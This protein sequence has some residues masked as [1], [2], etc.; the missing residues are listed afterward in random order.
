[1]EFPRR[2]GQAL[3]KKLPPGVGGKPGMLAH[4]GRACR[5]WPLPS[6]HLV[7]GTHMAIGKDIINEEQWKA[8]EKLVG[9]SWDQLLQWVLVVY[10]GMWV[11][12]GWVDSAPTL[13]P[14]FT[15]GL[16]VAA[17]L[18]LP[19]GDWATS[20]THWQTTLA[21][22]WLPGTVIV[23][24]AILAASL[25]H[26]PGGSGRMALTVAATLF[27][28][29]LTGDPATTLLWVTALSAGPAIISLLLYAAGRV[30]G[31]E[32][33][34]LE[35]DPRLTLARFVTGPLSPILVTVLAPLILFGQLVERYGYVSHY[36]AP[37][38]AIPLPQ[39]DASN[40]ERPDVV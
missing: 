7:E 15:W 29:E 21:P 36:R 25:A 1:M 27:A 22:E 14:P 39:R 32:P 26:A 3:T 12:W 13:Q 8:V 35:Y 2:I 37:T 9:L 20:L 30:R 4:L 33:G 6:H 38:G 10:A 5:G 24:S 11:C 40:L 17:D 34:K 31:S 23:V 18:G 19:T 28:I 16:N